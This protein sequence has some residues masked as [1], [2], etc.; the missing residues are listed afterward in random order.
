MRYHSCCWEEECDRWGHRVQRDV[1]SERSQ[2]RSSGQ[3]VT[4]ATAAT[5]TSVM[6]AWVRWGGGSKNKRRWN[7]KTFRRKNH[8]LWI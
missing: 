1:R 8:S 4:A 3:V 7:G 2:A 6:G 5:Q